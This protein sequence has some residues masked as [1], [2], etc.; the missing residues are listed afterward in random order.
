MSACL[1]STTRESPCPESTTTDV[2]SP[3]PASPL[4]MPPSDTEQPATPTTTTSPHSA[5]LFMERSLEL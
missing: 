5:R 4:M 2:T 1:A 3:L